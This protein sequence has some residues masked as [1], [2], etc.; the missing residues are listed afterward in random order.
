MSGVHIVTDPEIVQGYT[1]DASGLVGAPVGV[2]RPRDAEDIVEAVRHCRN[3]G[4][5]LTP[6][7][8]FTS[9]TGAPLA[10]EG[11]CLAI[12]KSPKNPRV[13]PRCAPAGIPRSQNRGSA[14]VWPNEGT[15]VERLLLRYTGFP[16][17][18][19][20]VGYRGGLPE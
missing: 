5:P 9:T 20:R 4:I 18:E 1:E 7:G 12:L 15:Q 11:L 17:T 2:I 16:G 6:A 14:F 3:E 8:R 10:M 19:T 13:A